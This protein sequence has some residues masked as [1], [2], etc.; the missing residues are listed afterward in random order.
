MSRGRKKNLSPGQIEAVARLFA[1]LSQPSRLA[2]LQALR[3]GSLNVGQLV[4]RC[5]MSQANVSK[6]L[7]V[8]HDHRLVARKRVGA[9]VE[10]KIADPMVFSL[11]EL[12]CGKFGRDAKFAA[13]LFS[14]EN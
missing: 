5:A 10:Y 2:L 13:T 8:L 12:V 1:V 4:A 7:A 11:C 6:N 3:A 14:P 9:S